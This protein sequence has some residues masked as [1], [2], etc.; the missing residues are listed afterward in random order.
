MKKRFVTA[1]EK[2][3][4]NGNVQIVG[5][6]GVDEDGQEFTVTCDRAS[7]EI[8][9][10]IN[11]Y[12]LWDGQEKYIRLMSVASYVEA[13]EFDEQLNLQSL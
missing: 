6:H 4:W 3:S 1:T 11:E 8:R 5:L 10:H 9:Q 2:N 12:F 13:M 7:K